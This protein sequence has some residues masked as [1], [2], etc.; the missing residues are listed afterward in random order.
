[1]FIM[2]ADCT[3]TIKSQAFEKGILQETQCSHFVRCDSRRELFSG[4]VKIILNVL[5]QI[6]LLE[7][8]N[9]IFLL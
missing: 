7:N 8:P 2:C 9:N 6:A 4:K 3:W 5:V 1:M